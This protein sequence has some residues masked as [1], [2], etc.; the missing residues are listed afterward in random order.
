MSSI[1][2]QLAG[3]K[4]LCW[5][6]TLAALLLAALLITTFSRSIT[7]R[8]SEMAAVITNIREGDIDCRYPVVYQDEISLIGGE[9]N[10]M[11]GIGQEDGIEPVD[12]SCCAVFCGG[13]LNLIGYF[14]CSFIVS[15][16]VVLLQQGIEDRLTVV[17][18]YHGSR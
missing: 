4:F 12:R 15:G 8:L 14:L 6:A 1:S 17:F 10:R 18:I 2:S 9:F 5:A 16:S 3:Y 11:G 7:S 13:C